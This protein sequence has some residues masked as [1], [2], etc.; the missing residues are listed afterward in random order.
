MDTRLKLYTDHSNLTCKNFNTNILL[1]WVPIIKE[2][3]PEIEYN[4]GTI[5]LVDEILKYPNNGN[6]NITQ[7]YN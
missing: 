3:G 7:E 4:Q 6:Q 1:I 2:Y 5:K